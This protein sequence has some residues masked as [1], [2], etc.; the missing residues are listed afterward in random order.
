[1]RKLMTF[2][3]TMICISVGFSVESM[4]QSI[5]I[6]KDGINQ[7]ADTLN[8][9][10]RTENNP[11]VDSFLVVNNSNDTLYIPYDPLYLNRVNAIPFDNS[12][13]EFELDTNQQRTRPF[14]ILPQ[15][16]FAIKINFKVD[17][18]DKGAGF[19]ADQFLKKG[20]ILI[21][22]CKIQDT[23]TIVAFDTIHL[24]GDRTTKFMKPS[25]SVIV[26]D[27][28]YIGT[29]KRDTLII[30]NGTDSKELNLDIKQNNMSNVNIRPSDI[31]SS[32]LAPN[33]KR[34]I[35]I[36]YTV[37]TLADSLVK[38]ALTITS[39]PGSKSQSEVSNI[40]LKT[41]VALQKFEIDSSGT[42]NVNLSKKLIIPNRN[43]VLLDTVV[44]TGSFSDNYQISLRNNGNIQ[45]NIDS[46]IVSGDTNGFLFDFSTFRKNLSIDRPTSF[47]VTFNP[48]KQPGNWS[49]MLSFY[50]DLRRRFPNQQLEKSLEIIKVTING[51]AKAAR[52]EITSLPDTCSIIYVSQKANVECNP[53]CNRTFILKNNGD[54]DLKIDS[55]VFFK[56]SPEFITDNRKSIVKPGETDTIKVLLKPGSQA[57]S[58]TNT[59]MVY[60]NTGN[61]TNDISFTSVSTSAII[62]IDTI[63][64]SPG[65]FISIPIKVESDQLIRANY[66]L[67]DFIIPFESR[68]AL[69]YE[70]LDLYSSA[71]EKANPKILDTLIKSNDT[72]NSDQL[73]SFG[74]KDV[75]LFNFNSSLKTLGTLK[76]TYFL[77]ES[78]VTEIIINN[79]KLGAVF[80]DST[81]TKP[82]K[83]LCDEFF[84][85]TYP[86][87]IIIKAKENSFCADQE[88][89]ESF[90][91]DIRSKKIS[92][93]AMMP[94][95]GESVVE[96]QHFIPESL[97]ADISLYSVTGEKVA[98][99]FS[100]IAPTE[101]TKRR[102]PLTN[103]PR[104]VYYCELRAGAFR[105]TIPIV[106]TQ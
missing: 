14:K 15:S 47:F 36:E 37:R 50:T 29:T 35:P 68:K 84:D 91:T 75:Q 105:K 6:S 106:I 58:F 42:L 102:H 63:E 76:F 16:T 21:N 46:V 20:R 82:K 72:N 81:N 104:G 98:T 95:S 57:G 74:Y 24:F 96:I 38:N 86:Q 12:F 55:V 9:G 79:Y 1:M 5:I 64:A 83:V 93:T 90:F 92:F 69:R 7:E 26:F 25:D 23:S 77:N 3:L 2:F 67:A 59:L 97:H 18:A 17:T 87:K 19:E 10:A 66:F 65:D 31:G 44:A 22:L 73:I 34:E 70:G 101:L 56:N 27:T 100:G 60:T 39:G 54:A 103:L 94:M 89:L 30:Y 51:I 88:T 13:A 71:A 8:F 48:K 11:K 85:V 33:D 78:T 99:I 40:D 61:F 53:G 80:V 43:S 62:T 4:A 41:F 45:L 32:T 49:A 28:M 52:P